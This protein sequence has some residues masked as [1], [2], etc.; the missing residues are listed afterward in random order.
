M[1]DCLLAVGILF[2]V[3]T[4]LNRYRSYSVRLTF[5]YFITFSVFIRAFHIQFS[6][7]WILVDLA[8]LT[9]DFACSGILILTAI[10]RWGLLPWIF[11]FVLVHLHRH[12]RY[13]RHNYTQ[14]ATWNRFE[15]E[16]I[17][18]FSHFPNFHLD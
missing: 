6:I 17:S 10:S 3:Q 1:F 13:Q 16:F 9:I 15:I 2:S 11:I 4:L 12:S 7:C 5:F 8:C 18:F 14:H